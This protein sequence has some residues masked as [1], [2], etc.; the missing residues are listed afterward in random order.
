MKWKTSITKIENGR[1]IVRGQNLDDLTKT[2]SF[3]EVVFLIWKGILPNE[4]ETKM[5]NA[6]LVS[7]IDHGVGAPSATVARIV[8]S[9]GNSMHTALSAGVSA[10]GELH[11]GAIEGAAEFFEKNKVKKGNM[12]PNAM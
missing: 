4:K 11:G 5:M 12:Y 1:E 10:L 9:S 7:C 2:K 3:A 8:A 6:L